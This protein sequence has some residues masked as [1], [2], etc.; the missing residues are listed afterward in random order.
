MKALHAGPVG[1]WAVASPVVPAFD[2]YVF[3]WN[4]QIEA[5]RLAK[6]AS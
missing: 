5:Q 1:N 2:L 6:V 4:R 3:V